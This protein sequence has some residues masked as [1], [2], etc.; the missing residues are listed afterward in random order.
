MELSVSI[1][2]PNC[3][4]KLKIQEE[5]LGQTVTCPRCG[6]RFQAESYDEAT[7]FD[8]FDEPRA[9]KR[10]R[11]RRKD[12]DDDYRRSRLP[13][14]AIWI[15]V[16]S[17]ALL[18]GVGAVAVFVGRPEAAN[19]P[20]KG[21]ADPG[22]GRSEPNLN[23]K[24]ATIDKWDGPAQPAPAKVPLPLPDPQGRYVRPAWESSD[25]G[26]VPT[27]SSPEPAWK[28]AIDA[29]WGEEPP[30]TQ[31]QLAEL[32]NTLTNVRS[33]P[34]LASL[35]SSL[36]LFDTIDDANDAQNDRKKGK[37]KG[38]KTE[39]KK[40][41]ELKGKK[42]PPAKGTA[43]PVARPAPAAR[44]SSSLVA[45]VVDLRTGK[46][47]V[48]FPGQ[49]VSRELRL[50]PG[51][52]FLV[53]PFQQGTGGAARSDGSLFVF[54]PNKADR[55]GTITMAGDVFW[56]DFVGPKQFAMLAI[57][58][59]T[60]EQPEPQRLRYVYQ[61]KLQ[62][63][64]LA[65]LK[66]IHSIAID[67]SKFVADGA[68]SGSLQY[69][70][71]QHWG[72]VSP[73]G[74]YVV[75]AAE[76][77]LILVSI[78]E[79]R[80]VGL[81]RHPAP[82]AVNSLRF[83]PDGAEIWTLPCTALGSFAFEINRWNAGTGA[84]LERVP[85][86]ETFNRTYTSG[87]GDLLPGPLP[88]TLFLRADQQDNG[89]RPALTYLFELNSA[90]RIS[91]G[92]QTVLRW[93][94]PEQLLVH[95][96]SKAG[97]DDPSKAG[98]TRIAPFPRADFLKKAGPVLAASA[99]RP[100]V[101]P[102][103][104]ADVAV[105]VPNP[106]AGWTAP[107]ISKTAPAP[108]TAPVE[109]PALPQALAGEQGALVEYVFVKPPAPTLQT[110]ATQPLLARD[111]FRGRNELHFRMIDLREGKMGNS[112]RLWP[113]ASA[114]DRLNLAREGYAFAFGAKERFEKDPL[115]RWPQPGEALNTDPFHTP[116]RSALSLD[117]E[118][119]AVCDPDDPSRVD[120][121]KKDGTH[122]AGVRPAPQA[123]IEWLGWSKDGKLLTLT[124]GTL[125]AWNLNPGKC[126]Y[127]VPGKFTGP[128]AFGPGRK[129]I[130]MA[131]EDSLDLI[132][133]KTGQCISRCRLTQVGGTIEALAVSPNGGA[134]AAARL[135]VKN[136]KDPNAPRFLIDVFDTTTGKSFS[137]AA[138]IL[139]MEFL[140]WIDADHL[141]VVSGPRS[142]GYVKMDLID[143]QTA[144][145]LADCV[146]PDSYGANL[147][148]PADGWPRLAGS[149]DGRLWV[150]LPKQVMPSSP[151]F[152]RSISLAP[153]DLE[154]V[155][156]PK[157]IRLEPSELTIRVEV[158]LG[159]PA[160]SKRCAED[161]ARFFASK[162]YR[163]GSNAW[164]FRYTHQIND[165]GQRLTS[166]TGLIKSE[167]SVP[168]MDLLWEL[169]DNKAQTIWKSTG[170]IQFPGLQSKY[171]KKYTS[172]GQNFRMGKNP[173]FSIATYD[174]GGKGA[175]QAMEEEIRELAAKT[176]VPRFFPATPVLSARDK[177]TPLPMKLVVPLNSPNGVE[178]P[179]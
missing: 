64:D 96:S 100:D 31:E 145:R 1:L 11:G 166:D 52:D 89:V 118:M 107:P 67:G 46:W 106:P 110:Y 84:L 17:L 49:R 143:R 33:A 144:C 137:V 26:M 35:G 4:A 71:W 169:L 101:L 69:R 156:D 93:L 125:A 126:H 8:E 65:Q 109:V 129:W 162:E 139:R 63:W 92:F 50:S 159:E 29:R 21:N 91:V 172:A 2:C 146:L 147:V 138:G 161:A 115:L 16:G 61:A 175:R 97:L 37:E 117:G 7:G 173:N 57:L 39:G 75:L 132:D 119:L 59:N 44:A 116:P 152:W 56:A 153:D 157:R 70:P 95:Y 22:K 51:G 113:W 36:A 72:A 27:R 131:R 32:S 168:Q 171:F 122:V 40:K 3:A 102:C 25:Q 133:S 34:A 105:A 88:R 140:H 120:A 18:I 176:P 62:V 15:T 98:S 20:A 178:L 136:A 90:A 60:K 99:A 114:A 150:S 53:S 142:S 127:A 47:G 124:S 28:V 12:A 85:L 165:S 10:K 43:P 86:T 42:R 6:N 48:R 30:P 141:L 160:L 174:F 128:I 79:G 123:A 13:R 130:A 170:R 73:N 23:S 108:P 9:K 80:E 111:E 77:G 103:R 104:L 163:I 66:E 68:G 167:V 74:T 38:A 81:A 158:D 135:A 41:Q 78:E 55:A 5:T 151:R 149:G 179:K 82:T 45:R 121:W 19:R 154:L 76:K 148:R 112:T 155:S 58:R 87:A 24:F 134:L 177:F 94:G 164:V 54:T 83:S 14:R